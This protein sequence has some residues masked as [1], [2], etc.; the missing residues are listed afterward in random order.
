MTVECRETWFG[1]SVGESRVVEPGTKNWLS[2]N[3]LYSTIVGRAIRV[4][5][6]DKVTVTLVASGFPMPAEY[7]REAINREKIQSSPLVS[8]SD[9]VLWRRRHYS[10]KEDK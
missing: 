10:W 3:S 9:L 8:F 7:E 6:P 2:I 4:D 5:S 1:R